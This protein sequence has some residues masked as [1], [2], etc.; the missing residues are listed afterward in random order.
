MRKK[1]THTIRT[2]FRVNLLRTVQVNYKR[3]A[4]EG[5]VGYFGFSWIFLHQ[6]FLLV[7]CAVN[8]DEHCP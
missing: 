8:R 4:I 6:Y 2:D 3:G 7:L 5:L 1:T